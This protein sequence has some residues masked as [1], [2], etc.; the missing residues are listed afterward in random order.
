MILTVFLSEQYVQA[1]NVRSFR[2]LDALQYSSLEQ[3]KQNF[4]NQLY[5]LLLEYRRK[6]LI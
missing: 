3:Q 1:N 4:S 5:M 6:V 2:Q